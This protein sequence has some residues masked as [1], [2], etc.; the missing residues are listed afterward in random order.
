[1]YKQCNQLNNQTTLTYFYLLIFYFYLLMFYPSCLVYT[2]T[3]YSNKICLE[4]NTER[5]ESNPGRSLG[6]TTKKKRAVWK[7][8]P[9]QTEFTCSSL[10]DDH[11]CS[12]S[13]T[14]KADATDLFFHGFFYSF[15]ICLRLP[16]A[17]IV[18]DY[19]LLEAIQRRIG[20]N[21]IRSRSH[22]KW[23]HKI[24]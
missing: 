11:K 15:M 10:R 7:T 5:S 3:N 6:T 4:A 18:T 2:F 21:T 23:L 9:T 1:M 16:G 24:K 8:V 14:D 12:K 20:A 17:M 22:I 13:I 19:L